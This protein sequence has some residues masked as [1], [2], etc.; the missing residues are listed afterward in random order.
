MLDDIQ[1]GDTNLRRCRNT[2][3]LLLT[4]SLYSQAFPPEERRSL[5][6]RAHL[7][8]KGSTLYY[9]VERKNQPIGLLHAWQLE[10]CLFIEHLAIDPTERNHG[11]G[12]RIISSITHQTSKPCLLEVEPHDGAIASRRIAFYERLGFSILEKDYLQPAYEGSNGQSLPLYL[13]GK[14]SSGN[15]NEAALFTETIHREVY[16]ANN[17]QIR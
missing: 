4:E 13:M 2:E 12:S 17:T 16:G 1:L 3:E 8:N 10:N 5:Q 14:G 7:L 9:R 11:L 6:E 15:P